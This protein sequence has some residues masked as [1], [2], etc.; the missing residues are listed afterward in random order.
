MSRII[1]LVIMATWLI[2]AEQVRQP[3]ASARPLLYVFF[4]GYLLLIAAVALGA[5]MISRRL[6][7]SSFR[8]VSRRFN[9]LVEVSRWAVPAWLAFG[10]LGGAYWAHLVLALVGG[11]FQLPALLVG[12]APAMLTW[13]AL[14]WAEYPANR[15]QWERSCLDGFDDD[16]PIHAPPRLR[17]YLALGLRQQFLPI[18]LPVLLITLMRDL[19]VLTL[20]SLNRTYADLAM[21]PGVLAVYLAAPEMLRRLLN[22][23]PMPDSPLRR[24]LEAICRRANLRY[25]DILR[26]DTDFSMANAAV[27][28]IL[29]GLRYVLLSDR[30]EETMTDEEIECVFAHELGH[31]VH[32]H[33]LWFVVLFMIVVLIG[34]GPAQIIEV[35]AEPHLPPGLLDSAITQI[36]AGA[37]AFAL[38]LYFLG[39]LAR[40]FERQA[41]VFAARMV[42]SG[43][44]LSGGLRRSHVGA[45][46]ASLMSTALKRVALINGV[47]LRQR[48]FFHPSISLRRLYLRRLATHPSLTRAFDRRMMRL[49]GLLLTLLIL[50]AAATILALL[51]F[52][53]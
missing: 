41:D 14:W 35:L 29:P 11:R 5:R 21:I 45:K 7:D 22:C 9:R 3:V 24:R 32:S 38:T 18:V 2:G 50:S 17:R 33:M 46:G 10:V 43:W 52:P 40:R 42:E 1:L 36:I 53:S 16:L 12:T 48:D 15:A 47:G 25:R 37:A 20:P 34:L 30:L 49:Y 8:R 28:G 44:A 6:P 27:V 31:I 26:W 51:S 39:V 23:R 4:A 19:L 13:I